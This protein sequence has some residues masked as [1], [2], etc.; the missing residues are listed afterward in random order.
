[1]CHA[2][3]WSTHYTSSPS[4]GLLSELPLCRG[5]AE[6]RVPR[7]HVWDWGSIE[8]CRL[9]AGC[10]KLPAQFTGVSLRMCAVCVAKPRC[11]QCEPCRPFRA[12]T[13]R[14][15]TFLE[16]LSFFFLLRSVFYYS[17]EHRNVYIQ[18]GTLLALCCVG[19]WKN[20]IFEGKNI[21]TFRASKQKVLL[22]YVCDHLSFCMSRK[23]ANSMCVYEH[24]RVCGRACVWVCETRSQLPHPVLRKALVWSQN[25]NS[26]SD[27]CFLWACPAWILGCNSTHGASWRLSCKKKKKEKGQEPSADT[28]ASK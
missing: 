24:M 17:T 23:Y 13:R 12:L 15:T 8:V 22:I 21:A 18:Q 28:S 6:P 16:S 7:S 1:M 5:T 27:S 19:S 3:A 14:R 4:A 25:S 9:G 26:L 2:A 10:V 20:S 11:C